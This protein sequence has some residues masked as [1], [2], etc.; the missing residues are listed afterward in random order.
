M[1]TGQTVFKEGTKYYAVEEGVWYEATSPGGPWKV[2]VTPPQKVQDIPPSNPR[3]NAKYV[4]VYDS[5]DDTA[6]VGYT[7]GYT[8][9]YVQ[10]G[11]V[12]YGTGYRYAGYAT[13]TTY[14]AY[15]ST[16][17]YAAVYDPYGATW[18]YQ[19]AYYNPHAWL[20]A[21]ITTAAVVGLTW[22]AWDSIWDHHHH[23]DGWY[24]RGGWWGPG[25][26][27]YRNVNYYHNTYVYNNWRPGRPG[28][29]PPAWDRP[30]RPGWERP[31][32][33]AQLPAGRPG[34]HPGLGAPERPNLYNRPWN[35]DKVAQRPARPGLGAGETRPG[36]P[37]VG[38]PGPGG[39]TPEQL[40]ATRPGRLP[41]QGKVGQNNVFADKDGNVFRKTDKGWQQREG[42]KWAP[43]TSQ[44]DAAARP[45]K[46][47]QVSAKERPTRNLDTKNLDRELNRRQRGDVRAS[48]AQRSSAAAGLSRPGGGGRSRGESIG[49]ARGG[50]GGARGGHGRGTGG[51]GAR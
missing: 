29:R 8:G 49:G 42:G 47:P 46:G 17:G 9:S 38:R 20:G 41:T 3:Y 43:A 33:P 36:R 39:A 18:G 27:R 6:Y 45:G 16:Y 34:Q 28:Y 23:H 32:R 5:T 40:P 12:V 51:R 4:K 48:R 26:Y 10:N 25:G 14:I 13:P 2:C 44:G 50:Q 35:Q 22:A 24:Y 21:A 15:P 7:P 31:G 1:N 19:P 11:T 30:G 37:E